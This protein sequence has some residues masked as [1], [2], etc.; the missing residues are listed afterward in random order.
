[1][2]MHE[3]S[4]NRAPNLEQIMDALEVVSQ[5]IEGGRATVTTQ[6]HREVVRNLQDQGASANTS[7]EDVAATLDA[8]VRLA[9]SA[10]PTV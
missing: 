3:M 1:M 10:R 7:K 8:L 2:D 9:R 4:H 5:W 6:V